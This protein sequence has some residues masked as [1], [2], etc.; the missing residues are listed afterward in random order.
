VDDLDA[1]RGGLDN[2][3]T[4]ASSI[5]SSSEHEAIIVTDEEAVPVDIL[6]LLGVIAIVNNKIDKH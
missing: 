4:E 2:V 1:D 3:N 6:F 5:A